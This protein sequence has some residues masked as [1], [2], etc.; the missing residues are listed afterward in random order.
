MSEKDTPRRIELGGETFIPDP[1]YCETKLG[2]ATRRT[3]QRYDK[4]GQPYVMI[5]GEKWR[6]L[7]ACAAWWTGRIV[8]KRPEATRR[9]SPRSATAV[10]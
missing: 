9:H 5:A 3:A 6:P 1:E 10:A 4:Q 7:N 8:R 2:G